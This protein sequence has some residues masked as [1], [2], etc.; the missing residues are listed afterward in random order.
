MSLPVTADS[1]LEYHPPTHPTPGFPATKRMQLT[2]LYY[3]LG[4]WL[5]YYTGDHSL[6]RRLR[7]SRSSPASSSTGSPPTLDPVKAREVIGE[8]NIGLFPQFGVAGDWP[9]TLF[10]HGS[11]DSQVPLHESK[12]LAEKLKAAGVKSKLIVVEGKEHTFD[13]APGAERAFG[14]LFDQATAFL[15]KNLRK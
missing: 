1:P 11:K 14:G 12:H 7:Q 15:V 9:P 6:S 4:E 13:Y 8:R 10:V 5:D 3:Q 2:G